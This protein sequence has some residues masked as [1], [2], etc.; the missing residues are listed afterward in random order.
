MNENDE[1]LKGGISS[2]CGAKVYFGYD[3]CCE[4]GEHCDNV[5]WENTSKE[6]Q[7]ENKKLARDLQKEMDDGVCE[8]CL[9]SGEIS[10]DERDESGNWMRGVGSQK[11]ICR[12]HEDE[13]NNQD[14]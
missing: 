12:I 11:C 10:T 9:G 13:F 7:T 5:P 1:I 14:R 4:C 3:I 6:A 8:F 2:C